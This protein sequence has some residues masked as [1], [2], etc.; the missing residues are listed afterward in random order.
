M[1][2][3]ALGRKGRKRKGGKRYPSG[4]VVAE[5]LDEPLDTATW[6][7]VRDMA[8]RGALDERLG[9]ELG[10]LFYFKEITTTQFDAGVRWV[11]LVRQYRK[12]V[13]DPPKDT[14]KVAQL[15]GGGRRTDVEDDDSEWIKAVRDEYD[16]AFELLRA[17]ERGVLNAVNKL[18]VL[19]QHLTTEEK[20]LAGDGLSLLVVHWG[21][22]TA[23][24]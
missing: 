17:A 5:L 11:A 1:E 8:K 15:E 4:Q 12:F 6:P 16:R 14:P 2:A 10:R 22:T 18:S 24:R 3:L 7:R 23:K 13:T 9:T 20:M 21:L 19:N